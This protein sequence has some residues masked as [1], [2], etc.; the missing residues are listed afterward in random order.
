MESI[1]PH[2][3][4]HFTLTIPT[5]PRHLHLLP[6]ISLSP[7]PPSQ[8]LGDFSAIPSLCPTPKAT[9]LLPPFSHPPKTTP[10]PPSQSCFF[11]TTW[12]PLPL[13]TLISTSPGHWIRSNSFLI[14]LPRF[15]SPP[16]PTTRLLLSGHL[17]TSTMVV[18]VVVVGPMLFPT[19]LL[20]LLL[21]SS[22]SPV[23]FERG[24]MGSAQFELGFCG[25]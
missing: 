1:S 20:R 3:K 23:S 18:V 25:F 12:T 6:P 13:W 17:L 21:R 7:P 14:R 16:P 8:N 15:F 2:N 9:Q 19:P 5:I 24:L 10:P 22:S 4:Q 11:S